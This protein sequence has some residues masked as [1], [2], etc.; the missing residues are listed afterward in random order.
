M[1][2]PA[3]LHVSGVQLLGDYELRLEF[4]DGV[5][6]DV[7]LEGELHGEVFAPLRDPE[8]FRQVAVN[9]ET[10]TIEWPNGADFAPEFLYESGRA[11]Q[12]VA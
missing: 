1:T 10:G 11:V 4:D 8:L 6:K 3:F 2:T 7:D 5:T 9:P 12:H